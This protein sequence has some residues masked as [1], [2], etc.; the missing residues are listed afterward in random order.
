MI[1]LPNNKYDSHIVLKLNGFQNFN[2]S[3]H[4]INN[5]ENTK[6]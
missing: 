2:N 6:F 4:A 3:K 5:T 1:T